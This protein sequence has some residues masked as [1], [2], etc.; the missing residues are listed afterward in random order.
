MSQSSSQVSRLT[1]HLVKWTLLPEPNKNNALLPVLFS[2]LGLVPEVPLLQAFENADGSGWARFLVAG[3]IIVALSLALLHFTIPL[4]FKVKIDEDRPDLFQDE[5]ED[6]SSTS[7][8]GSTRNCSI[9]R[10]VSTPK[11][12][13]LRRPLR[14]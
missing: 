14:R 11:I 10:C 4:H 3:V 7:F 9:I 1:R 12:A 13:R 8:C 2:P 6:S 5:G